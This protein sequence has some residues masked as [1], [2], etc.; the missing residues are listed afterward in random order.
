MPK[1]IDRQFLLTLVR[2]NIMTPPNP[3]L[4][5]KMYI[6]NSTVRLLC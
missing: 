3:E 1:S 6:V 5:G 2:T 4:R